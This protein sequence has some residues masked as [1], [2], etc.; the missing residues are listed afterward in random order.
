MRHA[1]E[2]KVYK[3]LVAKPEGKRPIGRPR[4]IWEDGNRMD[5]RETGW[6]CRV[7][8]VGLAP[9]ACSCEYGDELSGSGTT[10]LV[11]A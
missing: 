6:G 8:P 10:E 2:R 4:R 9:V 11:I 5:L 3:D 7:D 1:W